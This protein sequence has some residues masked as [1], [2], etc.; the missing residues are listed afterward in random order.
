M[1][2]EVDGLLDSIESEANKPDPANAALAEEERALIEK[3]RGKPASWALQ[4]NTRMA[5]QLLYLQDVAHKIVTG[6]LMGA[7]RMSAMYTDAYNVVDHNA[8]T[9]RLDEFQQSIMEDNRVEAQEFKDFTDRH[10]LPDSV[11]NPSGKTL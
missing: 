4:V 7:I 2:D 6:D 1:T 10:G 9:E 5:T 11:F 8:L 3:H